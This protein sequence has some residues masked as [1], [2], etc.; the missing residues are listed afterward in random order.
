M[1]KQASCRPRNAACFLC[2]NANCFLRLSTKTVMGK[3]GKEIN[4]Y[5][6]KESRHRPRVAQRV[7]E[8]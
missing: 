1:G 3:E 4:P 7:P 5:K 8:S 2:K 6:V